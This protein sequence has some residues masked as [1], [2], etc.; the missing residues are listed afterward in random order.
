M[1]GPIAE[2]VLFPLGGSARLAYKVFLERRDTSDYYE[3]IVDAA[4]GSL[5]H[6]HNMTSYVDTSGLVF[7]EHPDAQG[8]IPQFEQF[9]DDT[10]LTDPR[11]PLGWVDGS[12]TIG[13]VVDSKDDHAGDNELT[14]GQRSVDFPLGPPIT[15]QDPWN[16][17][18]ESTG[19]P[20]P[21]TPISVTQIF[22]GAPSSFALRTTAIT[23]PTRSDSS[24]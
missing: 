12:Q 3:V 19:D 6:R 14:E 15:F 2:V 13:N 1:Q 5:L 9:Y 21:D 7:R 16:N 20:R 17:S 8:G 18:W 11:W 22:A 23:S 10:V 24:G 4:D